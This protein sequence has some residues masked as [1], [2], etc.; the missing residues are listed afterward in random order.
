MLDTVKIIGDGDFGISAEYLLAI[1]ECAIEGGM[2]PKQI[3]QGT[4]IPYNTLI[5]PDVR[6]RHHSFNKLVL[7]VIHKLN[8]P[9]FPIKYAKRLTISRHGA[10]GFGIQSSKT[11][12]EAMQFLLRFIQTR[13]GGAWEK[14]G[15]NV[16][17]DQVR[18]H[19]Q[20]NDPTPQIE[21]EIFH[22][23]SSFICYE[24][25]SRLLAGE[26]GGAVK[27]E[28]LLSCEP[29]D[30]I[31]EYLIS[32]GLSLKFNQDCNELRLPID[33]VNRPLVTANALYFT[34]AKAEC[35]SE[36]VKLSM[37]SDILT[38]MKFH[39]RQCQYP[40]PTIENIADQMDISPRTLQRKLNDSGTTFL[41]LKN[42]ERFTQAIHLL[43]NT[44]ESLEKI[45]ERLGYSD[46]SNFAKAF[47]KTIGDTPSDYR[48]NLIL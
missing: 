27:T 46:S 18:I 5:K 45:S 4:N 11:L 26:H 30:E 14:V 38:Q 23:L 19:R 35:E 25:I 16:V 42:S 36:L 40:S 34:N 15:F 8:D 9:V 28:I 13:S 41:K 29:I 47:K 17:G 10:L 22:A 31:P 20:S 7:N 43:E 1:Y 3:F 39:I 37:W 21:L 32:P 6:I 33:F 2:T 12:K 24:A 44:K 48:K